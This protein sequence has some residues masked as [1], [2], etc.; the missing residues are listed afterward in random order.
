VDRLSVFV[1]GPEVPAIVEELADE[2]GLDP[3]NHLVCMAKLF[4]ARTAGDMGYDL[5]LSCDDDLLYPPDYVEVMRQHVARWEGKALVSLLT[6]RYVGHTTEWL[7]W[8]ERIYWNSYTDRGYWA[9][10]PGTCTLAFDPRLHRIPCHRAPELSDA[11]VAEWAQH[12]R[13]PV[14]NPPHHHGWLKYQLPKD[15]DT[16]WERTKAKNYVV[17]NA[18][19]SSIPEWHTYCVE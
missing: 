13:I 9:N 3:T 19:V 16:L 5:Y 7:K 17:E 2:V 4:W 8:H 11:F 1:N 15:A 6:R 10:Y 14:W 18:W 12:N